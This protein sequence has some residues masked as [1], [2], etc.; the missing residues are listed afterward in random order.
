MDPQSP[1]TDTA[2]AMNAMEHAMDTLTVPPLIDDRVFSNFSGAILAYAA[3]IGATDDAKSALRQLQQKIQN[4]SDLASLCRFAELGDASAFG[5]ALDEMNCLAIDF[6][7]TDMDFMDDMDM[8]D[9]N[10]NAQLAVALDLFAGAAFL[11]GNDPR[12]LRRLV[13]GLVQ[14]IEDAAGFP[15]SC[16]EEAA[17]YLGT[18]SGSIPRAHAA[19][20]IGNLA[21]RLIN[22]DTNCVPPPPA[23]FRQR[24][25]GLAARWLRSNPVSALLYGLMDTPVNVPVAMLRPSQAQPGDEV[26]LIFNDDID[27]DAGDLIVMFSPHLPAAIRN[28]NGNTI[29]VSVPAR[30]CTGPVAV[31][32]AAPKA[33]LDYVTLLQDNYAMNYPAEWSLS[34]FAIATLDSWAYPLAFTQSPQITITQTPISASIAVFDNKGRMTDTRAIQLGDTISLRVRTFPPGSGANAGQKIRVTGGQLVQS[35]SDL[36]RFRATHT[37][38]ATV[39]FSCGDLTEKISFQ[40]SE[41]QNHR[42]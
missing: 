29:S 31:L 36:I 1:T 39:Q 18:G 33:L 4:L 7:E 23:W 3:R 30:S 40:V 19:M 28:I 34:L 24:L 27:N 2:G 32:H 6:P 20:A 8:A 37:G 22:R 25:E 12:Q 11:S 15:L 41:K 17:T 38:T 42:R 35:G 13:I 21:G 5:R 10:S 9:P 26:D 14:A 16:V